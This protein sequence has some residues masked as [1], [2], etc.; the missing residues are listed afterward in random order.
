MDFIDWGLT[1]EE[2]LKAREFHARLTSPDVNN[3]GEIV[4]FV[5]SVSNT[6]FSRYPSFWLNTS[7]FFSL[8]L[9]GGYLNKK[10]ERPDIDLLLA[11][12]AIWPGGFFGEDEPI[13]SGL[14]Q[15][16][17]EANVSVVGELPDNY[18]IG[19][20]KGKALINI[21]PVVGKKID[22]IYFSSWR[23]GEDR[24]LEFLSEKQFYEL[25]VVDGKELPKL[26]LYRSV[27]GP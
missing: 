7:R 26:P 19:E 2:E 17:G 27:R 24:S 20:T 21:D 23:P 22:L 9:V 6:Y 5:D 14:K 15:S 3:L 13:Y 16:F 4:R 10:G 12:N 18:N 1:D 25:D 8:Y 11:T